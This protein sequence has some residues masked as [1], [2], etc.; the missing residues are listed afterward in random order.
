MPMTVAEMKRAVQEHPDAPFFC[1]N[2]QLSRVV[3]VGRVAKKAESTSNLQILVEDGTGSI[4]VHLYVEE[5]AG[6][7]KSQIAEGIYVKA[8]GQLRSFAEKRSLKA[9]RIIVVTDLDEVTHH[10]LAALFALKS[11]QRAPTSTSAYGAIGGGGGGAYG[12]VGG[13]GAASTSYGAPG[14]AAASAAGGKGGVEQ[15][16]LAVIQGNYDEAGASVQSICDALRLS[17]KVV[18]DAIDSL[19]T[20]GHVYSTIDDNHYKGCN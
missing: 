18:R 17:E 10:G 3:L 14:G 6:D 7:V 9:N 11:L 8:I 13:G 20:D 16:V 2:K 1:N 12:A 4:D 5:S 19:A 15:N